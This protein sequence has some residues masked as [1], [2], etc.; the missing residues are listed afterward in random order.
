VCLCVC[1][2]VCVWCVV[3]VCVCVCGYN[4]CGLWV[5][6]RACVCVCVHVECLLKNVWYR[7]YARAKKRAGG[8]RVKAFRD[9]KWES[10][11]EEEKRCEMQN[12]ALVIYNF[13]CF[14]YNFT[15]ST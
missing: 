5:C 11:T 1:V 6:V 12:S 7:R 3:C 4:R 8:G 2:C 13:T 9:W 14:V 15:C 10:R